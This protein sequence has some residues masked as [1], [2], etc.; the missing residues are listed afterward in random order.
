M[1]KLLLLS[2]AICITAFS[3]AQKDSTH[4]RAEPED[5]FPPAHAKKDSVKPVA[6]PAPV[7]Q[8]PPAEPAFF[9]ILKQSE[10]AYLYQIISGSGEMTGADVK[11]YIA[12]LEA[13]FSKIPDVDP[14]AKPAK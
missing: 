12:A 13:R 9:I 8:T 1:K 2:A 4:K 6:K 7:A 10:I 11:K 14:N 3:F 5:R